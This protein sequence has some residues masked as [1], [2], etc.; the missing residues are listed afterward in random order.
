[1][2]APFAVTWLK[3]TIEN[4][5][6]VGPEFF[7]PLDSFIFVYVIA[8]RFDVFDAIAEPLEGHWHR[9]VNELKHSTAG[10]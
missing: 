5:Q 9:F 4:R 1:M 7:S 10:Q 2:N 3:S 8:D 6:M